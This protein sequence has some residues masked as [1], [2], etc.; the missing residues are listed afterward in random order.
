[1]R[2]KIKKKEEEEKNK[3]EKEGKNKDKM[4]GHGQIAWE[5]NVWIQTNSVGRY[6]G[7]LFGYICRR[8]SKHIRTSGTIEMDEL[9]F[10]RDFADFKSLSAAVPQFENSNIVQFYK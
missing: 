5:L 8:S 4:T 6:S 2:R 10:G 9:G 1:M 7:S 3:K